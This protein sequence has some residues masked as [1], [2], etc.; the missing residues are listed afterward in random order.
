MLGG[1]LP[2]SA[3]PLVGGSVS[4]SPYGTQLVD[5]VGH[6]VVFFTLLVPSILISNASTRLAKP[7][8]RLGYGYLHLV[9]TVAPQPLSHPVL[10]LHPPLML[11]VL[12]LLNEIQSSSLGT[13]MFFSF[14][15]T[16]D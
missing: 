15:L 5:Y 6:M 9:P 12:L 14:S 13:S 3:S 7:C 11:I 16:V 1:H 4:V 10:S 8:L 2:T